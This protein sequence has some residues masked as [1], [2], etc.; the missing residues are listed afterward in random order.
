MAVSDDVS[1]LS[2]RAKDAEDRAATGKAE[3]AVRARQDAQAR[4]DAG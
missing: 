4:T 2:T 3:H 1:R